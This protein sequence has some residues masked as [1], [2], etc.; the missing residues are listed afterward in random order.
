MALAGFAIATSALLSGAL[1]TRPNLR[2]LIGVAG[3]LWGVMCIT[4]AVVQVG[5]WKNNQTLYT[6]AVLL[7]P[8]SSMAHYRLGYSYAKSGDWAE[9]IALFERAVELRPSNARAL[10]NLGVAYLNTGKYEQAAGSFERA[11]AETGQ[12]HFRAWY[13]LGVA[14]MNMGEGEAACDAV[15]RALQINP[16]YEAAAAFRRAR[17]ERGE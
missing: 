17:C 12:M 7:E 15:E 6:H 4:T 11:L 8:R 1:A 3:I 2:P 5:M 13:N 16:N 14:R 9:A 10:N